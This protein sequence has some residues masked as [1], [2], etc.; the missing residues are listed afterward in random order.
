MLRCSRDKGLFAVVET[1]CMLSFHERSLGIMRTR[2]YDDGTHP[3]IM[4]SDV[5]VD[6]NRCFLSR[7]S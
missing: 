5:L 1:D 6:N 2:Y 7:D 3:R 4:L